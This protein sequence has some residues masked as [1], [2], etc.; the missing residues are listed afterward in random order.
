MFAMTLT[1]RHLLAALAVICLTTSLAFGAASTLRSEGTVDGAMRKWHRVSVTFDGPKASESGKVNPFL[2]YRMTVTFIKGPRRIAIPGFF[3]ADGNA[4]ESSAKSGDQWRTYFTPDEEGLWRYEVSFRKGARVALSLDPEAGE[5]DGFDGAKGAFKIAPTDKGGRDLRGKGALRYNGTR[6]LQ[7]A[8]TGAY[9]LKGGADSPENFLAYED[10]DDTFRIA[11]NPRKGEAQANLKIHQYA[12][13]QNDWRESDPVWKKN[14]GKNIIGALNYLSDMGMNS[15][16]FLTMNV[17]GDG[18]DVWPWTGPDERMRFDCSKLDQWEIVFSHMD[19]LGL[20]MHVITQETENDQLLDG[21]DLGAERKLYYR[22]LIARFAHH[23]AIVWNFG[24]EN[25]NTVEQL[26]AFGDYFD[27]VD[28][29]KHPRV[30]HTYPN[31][32]DKVYTPLLGGG[33]VQGP[34]LQM[35][36]Q[37]KVHSETLKWVKRSSEAKAQWFVCLDEIGPANTGV[38]PD[39]DDPHHND[40]RYHSLWGNLMAGGAGC[41]WYFGYKFAHNDLNCEDWRSR[42]T[43]WKQTRYALDF[44]ERQLPFTEMQSSDDLSPDQDDY[45]FAKEG[46][47]YAVYAPKSEKIELTLPEGAY[48]VQWF[49]PREGGPLQSG[50]IESI[51]G[52]GVQTLGTPPSD[53]QKDWAVLVNK[54]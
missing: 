41:E 20:A 32:Y 44:F 3:A 4:A 48:S 25:T 31:Q 26:K 2:D 30:V 27:S 42:D 13:H 37:K 47:V 35:G 8:E 40:V 50:S 33:W 52:P 39:A 21:G 17:A 53:P 1:Q 49:N 18:K 16:Y 15:V 12:P 36:D 23:P 5:P 14:K 10:F 51:N 54:K 34:S 24:E 7:F 43:M 22:E 28:P 9:Y 29:Y 45:V 6:Y 19:Y 38:K 46:E 11:T